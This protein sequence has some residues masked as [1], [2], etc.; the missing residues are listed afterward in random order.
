MYITG[1][2]ASSYTAAVEDKKSV[3][4]ANFIPHSSLSLLGSHAELSIQ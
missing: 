1:I 2:G 4:S 3:E